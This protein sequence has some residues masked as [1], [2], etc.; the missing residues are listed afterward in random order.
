MVLEAFDNAG[1]AVSNVPRA[2][3]FY[4]EVLGLVDEGHDDDGASLRLGETTFWI[5]RT[6]G[7]SAV[8]R[9]TDFDAN[10]AGIDHLSFRVSDLDAAIVTLEERGVR[11]V[12]ATVGE[13]GQFRYRG[14]RDPDGT[15]LYVVERA[16]N[17]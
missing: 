2:V 15:M 5:F 3:S 8:D 13:P 14:F 12:G 7:P 17:S 16:S 10:P 11:F 9:S 6:S 1:I 4:T